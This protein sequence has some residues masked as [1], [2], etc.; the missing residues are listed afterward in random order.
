MR[1]SESTSGSEESAG[2]AGI[3]PVADTDE[4]VGA[5]DMTGSGGRAGRLPARIT[6]RWVRR[7]LFEARLAFEDEMERERR[8][9]LDREL[10][11]YWRARRP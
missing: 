4:K 1:S 6:P 11:R 2:M 5:V 3:D 9:A 7:V 8:R 10:E